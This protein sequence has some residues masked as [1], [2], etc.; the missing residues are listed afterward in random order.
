M[1]SEI[2]HLKLNF[3]FIKLKYFFSD[4]FLGTRSPEKTK[5]IVW[6]VSHQGQN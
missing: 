3:R 5:M 4:L 2:I 1:Y 6:K